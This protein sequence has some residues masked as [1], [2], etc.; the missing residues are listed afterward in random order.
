[1]DHHEKRD[2]AD[3]EIAK[4]FDLLDYLAGRSAVTEATIQKLDTAIDTGACQFWMSAHLDDKIDFITNW[5][6]KIMKVF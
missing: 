3:R 1:L 6:S 2:S 5:S 4:E